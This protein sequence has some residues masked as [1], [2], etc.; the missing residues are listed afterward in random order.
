MQITIK[1]GRRNTEFSLFFK[2]NISAMNQCIDSKMQH[3]NLHTT[4][5]VLMAAILKISKIIFLGCF[6]IA[7]VQKKR[8]F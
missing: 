2:Q 3:L 4:Y 8:H 5:H 6:F 7:H 1:N